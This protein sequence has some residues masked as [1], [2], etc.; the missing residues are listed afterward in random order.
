MISNQVISNCI[1]EATAISGVGFMIVNTDG[2]TVARS[3]PVKTPDDATVREFINGKDDI[4]DSDGQVFIKINDD[5]ETA[6]VLVSDSGK[7][8]SAS[9]SAAA[10]VSGART[11]HCR[12]IALSGYRHT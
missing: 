8:Q 5:G 9:L 1:D 6:F 11:Y 4:R 7:G 3:L 12:H 10:A 2:E